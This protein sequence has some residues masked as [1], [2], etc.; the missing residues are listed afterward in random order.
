VNFQ[1][2]ESGWVV[3]QLAILATVGHA[4]TAFERVKQI[5]DDAYIN[6]RG[7]GH[8]KSNT[9]WYIGTRPQVVNPIKLDVSDVRGSDELRPAPV[10]I[11]RNCY[12]PDTCT[13]KVLDRKAG[14]FTCR[15]RINWYIQSVGKSQWEAC[16]SVAGKDFPS[17]CGKCDPNKIEHNETSTNDEKEEFTVN[18]CSPCSQ[19]E[20]DSD[21]NRCPVT[22]RSFVCTKGSSRGGCNSDPWIIDESQCEKCCEMT[23]CLKKKDVEAKKITKDNVDTTVCPPCPPSIC[24]STRNQCQIHT[25]PYLCT[26]GPSVGGCS[27]LPWTVTNDDVCTACCEVT[28]DC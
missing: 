16:E 13:A 2:T 17:I 14:E 6:A 1:C 10:Y 11:L 3:L 22:E 21:L 9:I 4:D 8:S 7:N 5:P 20:C 23:H 28:I 27:A 19:E 12:V 26:S 25:A 15:E 24:Y 18:E